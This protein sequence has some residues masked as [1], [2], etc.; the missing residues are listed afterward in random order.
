VG[1]EIVGGQALDLQTF[2]STLYKASASRG[3]IRAAIEMGLV[4]R[5]DW[6]ELKARYA[7]AGLTLHKDF[8]SL[9]DDLLNMSPRAPIDIAKL[10][11]ALRKAVYPLE[12]NE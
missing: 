1:A 3:E 11:D 9:V 5:E 7:R 6:Q 4:R 10:R 8:V 2:V 12:L